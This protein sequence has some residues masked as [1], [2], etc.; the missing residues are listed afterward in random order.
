MREARTDLLKHMTNP[1]AGPGVWLPLLGALL[2]SVSARAEPIELDSAIMD[3]ITAGMAA[4]PER[5]Q[6]TPRIER[7][8][9]IST[10]INMPIANSIA[11]CVLCSP[12]ASAN[13]TSIAVGDAQADSIATAFGTAQSDVITTAIGLSRIPPGLIEALRGLG[14]A[15]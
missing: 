5:F 6:I 9:Q 14:A 2:L 8:Q 13:A 11:I 7:M 1:L 4:M 15:R 3:N 10:Q 12:G